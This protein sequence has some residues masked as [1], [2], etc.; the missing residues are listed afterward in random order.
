MGGSGAS[1]D[2]VASTSEADR[3]TTEISPA[4]AHRESVG[5]KREKTGACSSAGAG[6]VDERIQRSKSHWS[7][8]AASSCSEEVAQ[9]RPRRNWQRLLFCCSSNVKEDFAAVSNVE[10]FKALQRDPASGGFFQTIGYELEGSPYGSMGELVMGKKFAE[11]GQAE[12]YD[13][14]CKWWYPKRNED[15]LRMG[16]EYV[17]KVFK[18]G[19]FL[20]D[21]KSQLPQGLLKVYNEDMEIMRSSTPQLGPRFFSKVHRGILLRDGRFA[22]LMEK[23]HLD[24]RNLIDRNM[25]LKTSKDLGPF[26]KEDVEFMMYGVALGIHW[27]HS[28][29]IVHRD[30]KA[31]N[32]LVMEFKS[33]Y[34]RSKCFVADYECSVGVVGTGFFRAPEILQACK[35]GNVSQKPEVFSKVA[36]VYGYGMICYEILTGKLPF[37]DH[38]AND[39][40]RV[41]SGKCLQLP[42]YVEKWVCKL[43]GSCWQY[44]PKARPTIGE[45]LD[46]FIAHSEEARRY[47]E[48][49]K[50]RYG[51]NYRGRHH[52]KTSNS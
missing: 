51:E 24:L 46:V 41:L 23:E 7:T 38:L 12:L 26:P 34:P 29:D 2:V 19:T 37:E 48:S 11:G 13:V 27:L 35:D 15:D 5:M 28:N 39:Y 30:L 45:I 10:E 1:E 6:T 42:E 9:R 43:L 50:T 44:D 47:Q 32:V 8:L 16:R 4:S 36:D 18:K 49:L 22:F 33:G 20:K 25:K 31:S 40:N 3:T 17:L 14:Q 21:L 52:V